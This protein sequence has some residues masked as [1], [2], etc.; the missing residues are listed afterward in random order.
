MRAKM[1]GMV[2]VVSVLALFVWAGEKPSRGN[3]SGQEAFAGDTRASNVFSLYLKDLSNENLYVRMDAA[4]AIR[5]EQTALVTH[6]IKLAQGPSWPF[7]TALGPMPSQPEWR[8][9]KHQAMLLLGDMRAAD[10][11]PT[12]LANLEYENPREFYG[13]WPTKDEMYPAVE[14]LS[15]I[16][17]TAVDPVLAKLGEVDPT[18]TAAELCCWTLRKILGAKLGRARLEIAIEETRDSSVRENLRAALPYFRT[19]AEKV[20][21]EYRQR[22]ATD[23]TAEVWDRSNELE[24][25]RARVKELKEEAGQRSAPF[26]PLHYRRSSNSSILTTLRL[27]AAMVLN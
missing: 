24:E 13:G 23:T 18:S 8:E 19:S 2:A 3:E 27:W 14:A 9:P 7:Q 6:L 16:G 21:D 15:K 11:V 1:C 4:K 22:K 20:A 12:L 26:G 5:K 10:A 17:M 25:L